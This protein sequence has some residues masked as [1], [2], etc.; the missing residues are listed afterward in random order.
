MTGP[1]V[2]TSG[3]GNIVDRSQ[4]YH[5]VATNI[6]RLARQQTGKVVTSNYVLAELVALLT[7]PLQLP[8]SKAVGFIQ[9]LIQSP[10]VEIVH[11][12]QELDALS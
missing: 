7:S 3:W 4:P 2:D 6:Y 12:D 5:Q 8:R 9:S 10:Y 11:V 1:F